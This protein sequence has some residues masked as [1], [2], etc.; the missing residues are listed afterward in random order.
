[1]NNGSVSRRDGSLLTEIER[2]ALDDR[3]PLASILRKCIALG[4]QA[5]NAELRDW[6]SQELNGYRDDD[7]AIPPYRIIYAPLTVD[8]ANFRFK[9][10]G[11]QISASDL[12]EVAHGTVS[13][14]VPFAQGVGDLEALVRNTAKAGKTSVMLSP[15]GAADLVKLMNYERQG[16]GSLVSRLYWDVH[17]GRVEGIL[18]QIR[19]TLVRLTS[20]IRASMPSDTSVPT[21]EQAAQA[22]NVVLHGG[23][24]NQVT[25][26]TA[27]TGDSGTAEVAAPPPESH[28]TRTQTIWTIVGVVV[29]VVGAYFAYRQWR[30]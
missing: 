4:A 18:D 9:I 15:P 30:G 23:T 1:V 20:E 10:S 24:R 2:D 11:E 13:E 17:I 5:R 12:P 29:A 19:T 8:G 27:Q 25:V 26:T 6:A 16:Q 21:A 22:I 3:V 28:W 7:S 14:E